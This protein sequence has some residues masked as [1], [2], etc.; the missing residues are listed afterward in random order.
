MCGRY[1][2]AIDP[3][4]VQQ[5]FNLS[6][7]PQFL[8]RFNVAPTQT[9]P[10]IT[11]E[12]PDR[13]SMFRWGLIPS[14]SKDI[15]VGSRMINARADSVDVKPSFR[16]ALKKRRCIVPATGFYEWR[17]EADGK[18]KQPLYIH[19]ADQPLFGLAGLWE[20]WK[21]PEGEMIHTYTIITT[22]ANDFMEQFH[23]RMPVILPRD[24]YSTWLT[25]DEMPGSAARELLVPYT[26]AMTAYEVSKMVNK[27]AVDAPECIAPLA[28]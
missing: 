5:E 11:N 8:P 18:G 23:N 28:S 10:V 19:L 15:S 4:L 17:I 9:M 6:E 16:T 2:L 24:A 21:S 27:P 14:W 22:D 13:V 12:R 26:G 7:V 1:V 25:P 3:Q 20:F